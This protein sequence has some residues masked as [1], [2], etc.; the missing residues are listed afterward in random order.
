VVAIYLEAREVAAAVRAA[1][2]AGAAFVY[3]ALGNA[4]QSLSDFPKAIECHT[5]HLAIAKEVGNR[6]AEGVGY[7]D[8]GIAYQSLGDFTRR[9]S[10]TRI[11]CNVLHFAASQCLR[12]LILG[13]RLALDVTASLCLR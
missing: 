10:A 12:R 8:L 5:Q 6:V 4:Y 3:K 2:P 1:E 9:S 7:R 11:T 13:L